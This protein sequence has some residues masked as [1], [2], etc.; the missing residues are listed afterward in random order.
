MPCVYD[1]TRDTA[2]AVPSVLDKL[3]EQIELDPADE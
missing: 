2:K 3:G 1:H